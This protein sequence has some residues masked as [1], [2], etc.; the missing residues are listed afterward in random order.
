MS[1]AT[2]TENLASL[3]EVSHL[4]GLNLLD[5]T[6][7]TVATLLNQPGTA[8]SVRVYA[9][10]AARFGVLNSEAAQ[11]GIALYAEH[12]TDAAANPGKHPNIDRLFA[13]VQGKQGPLDVML[14]P[15]TPT[16]P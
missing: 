4:A 10:L 11:A 1:R 6:G 12:G 15:I 9:A 8:G 13:V 7:H 5:S 16:A 2:F 3:P 14:L